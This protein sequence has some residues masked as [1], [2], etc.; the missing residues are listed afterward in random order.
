MLHRYHSFHSS[1]RIN[2]KN[3]LIL[4]ILDVKNLI[5]YRLSQEDR[6]EGEFRKAKSSTT[7]PPS[8][9]ACVLQRIRLHHM[10]VWL[11]FGI[12]ELR[13]SAKNM[14]FMETSEGQ[15][16][17]P[18]CGCDATKPKFVLSCQ[19]IRSK[20]GSQILQSIYFVVFGRMLNAILLP[21]NNISMQMSPHRECREF[22]T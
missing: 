14:T 19:I 3:T 15:N 11:Y 17:Y 7:E 21:P 22:I 16:P 20:R 13:Y 9:P 5:L 10:V 2:R 6:W 4:E 18:R 1:C 12:R 8:L